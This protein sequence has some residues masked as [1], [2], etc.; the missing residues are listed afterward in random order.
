MRVVGVDG[1]PGGWVA[2]VYDVSWSKLHFEVYNSFK[3]LLASQPD[4]AC[5]AV[6]IPIGMRQAGAR[7]CDVE[8]REAI[9]P[10]RSSVFPAPDPLLLDRVVDEALDYDQT[11]VLSRSLLNKGI[12]KQAFAIFPEIAEVNRVMTPNLQKRVIE[13]HPEVCFWALAGQRPMEYPKKRPEGFEERRNHL[14]EALKGAYVPMRQEAGRV[15]PPA[16]ADDVLDA[17]VAARTARRFAEGRSGR[18]PSSPP[19]DARGLRMEMVY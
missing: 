19:T 9:G 1:C 16:K 8:A 15:A 17:I 18:L 11:N 12:S 6:D 4:A 7:S 5:I 10:R 13:V 14:L 2:A 3:Q